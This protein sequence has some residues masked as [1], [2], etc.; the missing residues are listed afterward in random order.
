M[1]E[2]MPLRRFREPVSWPKRDLFDW[3]ME[4]L[5]LPDFRTVNGKW[6]PAFDVSETENEVIVKAELPG[7]D[8]KDIDITEETAPSMD[9]VDGF[10]KNI[11]Q[12]VWE[13]ALSTIERKR[14]LIFRFLKWKFKKKIAQ[15]EQKHFSGAGD[16]AHFKLLKSYR[17]MLYKKDTSVTPVS[18]RK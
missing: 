1:F 11:G 17:L 16:G 15:L 2:L 7:M 6:L 4:D 3:F 13:L 9:L 10:Q 5:D 14:P 12:P 18:I 8:V